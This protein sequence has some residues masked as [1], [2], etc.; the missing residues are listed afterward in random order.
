MIEF[1]SKNVTDDFDGG[2]SVK[3]CL[4]WFMGKMEGKR[5]HYY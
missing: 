4:E 5:E 1:S 2:I 3:G